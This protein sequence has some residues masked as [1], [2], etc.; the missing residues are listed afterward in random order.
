MWWSLERSEGMEQRSLV[1]LQGKGGKKEKEE[2]EERRK[3][4]MLELPLPVSGR[5]MGALGSVTM[6]KSSLPRSVCPQGLSPP[7]SSSVEED[8]PR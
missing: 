7:G 5:R 2:K 6:G 8:E 1:G 3:R 4:R